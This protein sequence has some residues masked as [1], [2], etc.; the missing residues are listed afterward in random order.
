MDEAFEALRA[1]ADDRRPGIGKG[2]LQRALKEARIVDREIDYVPD[3]PR[4]IREWNDLRRT[5]DSLA[6][7]YRVRGV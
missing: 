7:L 1:K 4:T 3:T 5:L 6:S 2:E